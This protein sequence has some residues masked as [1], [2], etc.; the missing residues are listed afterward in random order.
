MS[1]HTTSDRAVTPSRLCH[2]LLTGLALTVVLCAAAAAGAQAVNFVAD[3]AFTMSSVTADSAGNLY[4]TTML[5]GTSQ[6]CRA[7][8]CGTVFQTIA[9]IGRRVHHDTIYNFDGNT[10]GAWPSAGL[11]IDSK[12]R[13][14][15]TTGLGGTSSDCCGT[16]FMLSRT[17]FGWQE[18]I[19]HRFALP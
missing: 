4:G 11:V 8:G 12:G 14:F 3:T 9:R 1:P 7:V 17:Q 18:T 6:N 15:G 16:V 13:L 5:G 2:A 19:L 10:D